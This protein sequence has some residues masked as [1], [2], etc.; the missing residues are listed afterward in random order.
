MVTADH[1]DA[2]FPIDLEVEVS[3][4]AGQPTMK[5]FLQLFKDSLPYTFRYERTL[6]GKGEIAMSAALIND[7]LFTSPPGFPH[8]V[9]GVA[10]WL[11]ADCPTRSCDP[12][13]GSPAGCVGQCPSLVAERIDGTVSQTTG[14]HLID[15][16]G[17]VA[18][19]DTDDEALETE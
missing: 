4:S 16:V 1:F 19:L 8:S 7:G 18:Q 3:L 14:P 11:A 5:R 9:D 10:P 13:Q 17:T 2:A 6:V 15:E 12:V